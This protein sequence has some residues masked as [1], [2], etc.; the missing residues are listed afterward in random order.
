[1]WSLYATCSPTNPKNH[2]KVVY[3]NIRDGRLHRIYVIVSDLPRTFRKLKVAYL[4]NLCKCKR[5]TYNIYVIL[6]DLPTSFMLLCVTYMQLKKLYLTCPCVPRYV[7]RYRVLMKTHFKMGVTQN[8]FSS[9]SLNE[10]VWKQI[11]TRASLFPAKCS[12]SRCYKTYFG[13]NLD[14]SLSWN[15]KN[16]PF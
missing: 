11:E 1:M 4:Y 2:L 7:F 10:S 5:P 14:L 16:R 15:S 3:R 8:I 6:S 9:S 12:S 13:G